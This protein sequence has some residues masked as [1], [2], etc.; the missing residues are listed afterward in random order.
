MGVNQKNI[1][2]V[3]PGTQHSHHLARELYK[4]G[5]LYQFWTCF[6]ITRKGLLYKTIAAF[7]KNWLNKLKNRIIAVDDASKIKSK[8]SL[9]IETIFKL[10]NKSN[11]TEDIYFKRNQ[12]FQQ[13]VPKQSLLNADFVVGFDSTSWILARR[14][15]ELGK[16]FILD[17]S[18]I[19]S[20]SRT[21][22][23]ATLAQKYPLWDNA[24]KQKK[25]QYIDYEIEE[26]NLATKIVVASSFTKQSLIDNGIAANKITVIPYGVDLVN[27]SVKKEKVYDGK[28]KFI[29]A[30]LMNPRKGFMNLLDVFEILNQSKASLTLL[31][32]MEPEAVAVLKDKKNINYAG[33]VS[34]NELPGIFNE[35]DVFVFPSYFEGFG[36]VILE[37]M[38]CGL[39]VIATKSSG[40]PDV[41]EN[42]VDGF[43]IEAGNEKQLKEAM[44]FFMSHPDKMEEMAKAARK[45]AEQYTWDTYGNKWVDFISSIN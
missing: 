11:E 7:K 29:F 31:G 42:G 6:A 22:T 3:H 16:P 39:P 1:L 4:K 26:L 5:F 38:A 43:I 36:L 23:L 30:S 21:T 18:S 8:I 17:V 2:I 35:H 10:R 12:K 15:N 37:A 40:A 45:K 41:I 19:H 13:K 33:R 28:I 25:Q 32:T 34:H 44:E 14:C 24:V 20:L 27:F 9:E